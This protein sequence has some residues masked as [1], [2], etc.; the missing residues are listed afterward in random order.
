MRLSRPATFRLASVCLALVALVLIECLL[1]VSL[2]PLLT[3]IQQP[4]QT[5]GMGTWQRSPGDLDH[6]MER[7]V[8]DAGRSMVRPASTMRRD[9]WM[10]DQAFAVEADPS[11]PR[12]ICLGGSATQ[13]V[14][15][16]QFPALTWPGRLE[17]SLRGEGIEAEVINL[18]GASFATDQVAALTEQSLAWGPSALVVY[19]GNNEFFQY[20]LMWTAENHNWRLGRHPES[21]LRSM[22]LLAKLLGRDGMSAGRALNPAKLHEQQEQLVAELME[23]TILE[24]GMPTTAV[25]SD[26]HATQVAA[27]HLANMERMAAVAHEAGVPLFVVGI[28]AH[29]QHPPNLSVHSPTLG[30][31]G[32][33]RFQTHMQR[34]AEAM[35]Q[36]DPREAIGAFAKASALDPIHAG[37]HHARGLARL[38]DGDR[39]G[40]Q[41]DL[42]RALD[43]DMNPERPITA[44]S[45]N[46]TRVSTRPGVHLVD[47]D[48]LFG[49]DAP[50][51]TAFGA[52]LFL[53]QGHLTALGYSRLATVISDALIGAGVLDQALLHPGRRPHQAVQLGDAVLDEELGI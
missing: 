12:I 16:E 43:L 32:T 30:M 15:V 5:K 31:L 44:L 7:F 40:A 22:Q 47:V 33:R 11:H 18:G 27:H 4:V 25:R 28:P 39:T 6:L 8:D 20:N 23:A 41:E 48:G 36:D 50:G 45:D 17:S 10:Q 37:A 14:P 19:A 9:G 2:P 21:S 26:S 46:V 13:G 29:L 1:Q 38:A 3:Q 24:E 42:R 35:A 51:P 53:D 49:L 34:G 52:H